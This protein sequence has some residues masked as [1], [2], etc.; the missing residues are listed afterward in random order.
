MS[1]RND[2][3]REH[4]SPPAPPLLE[5]IR[6]VRERIDA[7]KRETRE[8]GARETLLTLSI[9]ELT[10]IADALVIMEQV[11]GGFRR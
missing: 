3:I 10:M 9:P 2:R 1:I 5:A 4:R 11:T 8:Q 7:A 6:N